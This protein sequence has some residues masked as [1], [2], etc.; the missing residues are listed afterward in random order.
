M[1]KKPSKQSE[2]PKQ[3]PEKKAQ[4]KNIFIEDDEKNSPELDMHLMTRLNSIMTGKMEQA[5][6]TKKVIDQAN[7]FLE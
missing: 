5:I 3:Q 2:P 4:K 7:Q 6:S 1:S